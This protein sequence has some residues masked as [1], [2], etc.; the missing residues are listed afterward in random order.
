MTKT[1]A[2]LILRDVRRYARLVD[3]AIDTND[4]DNLRLYTGY[5]AGWASQ[6]QSDIFDPETGS[7]LRGV[8]SEEE[9]S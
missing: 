6:L 2:R 1:E 4:V 9:L 7:G 5:L 8:I 3:Y